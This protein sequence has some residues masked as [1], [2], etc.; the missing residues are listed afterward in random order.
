[1]C[2]IVSYT[3]TL[4]NKPFLAGAHHGSYS[5]RHSQM[6][7]SR[8]KKGRVQVDADKD[9]EEL[10]NG[11]DK[12]YAWESTQ[13]RSWDQIEED[14]TTGRLKS[15]DKEEEI[16]RKRR[17]DDGLSGVRRG[18]IRFCV[19]VIDMSE[20]MRLTDLKPS[21]GAL[22]VNSS[23]EF[24]REFFDQNPI[25]QMSV[26]VTRDDVA[27]KLSYLT[28]NPAHHIEAVQKAL[29]LGPFGYASLQNAL[30]LSRKILAPVP[31]YGMREVLVTFGALSTC[32]PGD[33]HAS[34]SD[35]IADKVRCSAVGLTAE[36]H[37]LK[38]L[39]SRTAGSYAV[40]LNENHF[41]EL[42]CAH[43]C[44]PPT[45]VTQ[46]SASLIRM[47][48]PVRKYIKTPRPFCNNPH[49]RGKDGYECPRCSAWVSHVP[50]ECALCGMTLVSS[51]HLARS[52]HHLF[53][54]PKYISSEDASEE[55][56]QRA[57]QYMA[58]SSEHS[59][60]LSESKCTGCLKTLQSSSGLLLICPR[61]AKVFCID[62]DVFVHDALHHCPGCDG[63]ADAG[64]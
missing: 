10:K 57:L 37:I 3:C 48:F 53:P 58:P 24:I 49:D 21:R 51:P 6:S 9:E 8:P 31:A 50:S 14:P 15:F 33:I 46:V 23:I 20:T 11:A 13:L 47:G 7:V 35:L 28:S 45:T 42:L 62:C 64:H 44:P 36:L 39:T 41:E 18:I 59:A 34:I 60:D 54:V 1:M 17:R 16:A 43:V 19:L 56:R 2:M 22:V 27:T 55:L 40:A 4:G 25:S 38:T 63:I 52:Y 26:V 30:D 32:D 5:S 12:S 61:C 29:R